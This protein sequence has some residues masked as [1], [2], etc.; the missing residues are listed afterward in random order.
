MRRASRLILILVLGLTI[1]GASPAGASAQFEV[2]A[3]FVMSSP[4]LYA[5]EPVEFVNT[6]TN[7]RFCSD[8]GHG[9]DS[10]SWRFGDGHTDEGE[11]VS[12]VFAAPGSYQVVLSAESACGADSVERTVAI[13]ARPMCFGLVPTI[14]H[15]EDTAGVTVN[16]TA[17]D[18]VIITG[19]GD[20][21]VYGL[22]GNDVICTRGGD[23]FVQGGAG[24]DRIHGAAGDDTLK[25]GAG[26]DLLDAGA[27]QDAA[28]GGD[29]DD[30]LQGQAGD[31]RLNG[32][33]E[34]DRVLGGAGA[35]LLAGNA[36]AADLCRGGPDAGEPDRLADN[37][38]CETTT[39]V[40]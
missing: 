25:G 34:T 37:H 28:D 22:G 32:G 26:S 39:E 30:V 17:G 4:P 8:Q 38:G 19:S 14:D 16:G 33:N 11:S 27:G 23:D 15:S 40:P 10:L 6:S 18:D 9:W 24:D 13:L 36:G 31:D 29:G 12:H 2:E 5:G 3:D 1:G 7:D 35:D 20:D 21:T